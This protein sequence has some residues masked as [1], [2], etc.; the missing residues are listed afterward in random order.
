[1]TKKPEMFFGHEKIELGL[2][3]AID[4]ARGDRSRGKEYEVRIPNDIDVGLIRKKLKF[5]QR[6][7]ALQFGF[8]LGTLQNWEQGIRKPDGPSR[9]L[10][11]LIARIPEQVQQAL[12]A[13]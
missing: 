1:M 8:A 2:R 5:S 7:F 12:R 13:A 11:T 4:Y 6:E 9:V 10:L 3:D